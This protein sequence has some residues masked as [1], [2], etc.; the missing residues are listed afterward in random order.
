M[1]FA[2]ECEEHYPGVNRQLVLMLLENARRN[3]E[4]LSSQKS[5]MTDANTV[6]SQK[7]KGTILPY[8]S[9]ILK[10]FKFIRQ[11]TM[12]YLNR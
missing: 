12:K 10:N 9:L 6:Q 11:K 3:D 7:L 2:L 8:S 5:M 4:I 1:R